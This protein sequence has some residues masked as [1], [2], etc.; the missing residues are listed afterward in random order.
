MSKF[1]A[2]APRTP[3]QQRIDLATVR[4][5]IAYM[6]DDLAG[7]PELGRV[8]NALAMALL[9]IERAETARRALPANV[10]TARFMPWTQR[11]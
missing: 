1:I 3:P 5:T 8:R 11:R 7:A 9:E 2:S 6:H 4:E 10:T